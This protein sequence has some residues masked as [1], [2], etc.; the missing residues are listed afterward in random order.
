MAGGESPPNVAPVEGSVLRAD[1]PASIAMR[2]P[3]SAILAA[4]MVAVPASAQLP[5]GPSDLAPPSE[6]ESSAQA[7]DNPVVDLRR[8][9]LS[10]AQANAADALRQA[11][12]S[13]EVARGLRICDLVDRTRS[14][15]VLARA[16]ATA[17]PLGGPRWVD[18]QT[19]QV[20]VVIPGAAVADAVTTMAARYPGGRLPVRP[21]VVN[22]RLSAWRRTAFSA[23]GSSAAGGAALQ[24]A[25]P[26]EAGG[27]WSE[28]PD[29]D[30]RQAVAAALTD[31]VRQACEALRRAVD[32]LPLGPRANAGAA[33]ARP[34]VANRVRTFLD[35]QPVTRIEF[36]DDLTVSLSMT[37]DAP[38][39]ARTVRRAVTD[40]QPRLSVAAGDWDR[41]RDAVVDAV[42]PSVTGTAA[43]PAPPAVAP[44]SLP[45]GV[46]PVQPPDWVE[47]ELTAQGRAAPPRDAPIGRLKVKGL[48]DADA[49][50]QLRAQLLALRVGPTATL[51]DAARADPEVAAAVDRVLLDAREHH[52]EFRADGS[53]AVGVSLNLRDAWDRLR[54]NP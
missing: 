1:R 3:L 54:S 20:Q 24:Q 39:L 11:V 9:Q 45:A 40:D 31:A 18:E 29:A 10:A 47:G 4:G 43:A 6:L 35:A 25:R 13:L 50:A 36:L 44:A 41:L 37:V 52:V 19:C 12:L 22:G 34:A 16:L 53:V 23:T 26:R 17:R 51:A 30:R 32:P 28:V 46:L 7:S 2:I 8:S 27:R 5:P 14:A 38:G 15:D 21:D 48:A 42:P 33:L 49:I